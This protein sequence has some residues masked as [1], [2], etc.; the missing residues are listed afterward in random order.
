MYRK[1]SISRAHSCSLLFFTY[2]FGFF[3]GPATLFPNKYTWR[4]ILTL[5]AW[6]LPFASRFS[7]FSIS[8]YHFFPCQSM[9]GS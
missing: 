1:I 8:V 9:A 2:F 3:G 4:H 6:I 7:P 5:N